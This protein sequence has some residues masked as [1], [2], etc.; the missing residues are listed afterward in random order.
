[1]WVSV[2]G[3]DFQISL[4]ALIFQRYIFQIELIQHVFV[5]QMDFKLESN[6][7]RLAITETVKRLPN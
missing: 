7:T 1:M 2:V 3:V 6:G 5:D 4:A